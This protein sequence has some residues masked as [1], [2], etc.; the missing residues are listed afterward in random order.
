MHETRLA[1]SL[2]V[3]KAGKSRAARIAMIAIT[4]NNSINV[5]ADNHARTRPLMTVASF[6]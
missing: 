1:F 5:N 4:T 2:A 6:T 3:T